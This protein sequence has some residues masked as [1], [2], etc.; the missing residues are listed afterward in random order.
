[1]VKLS[2]ICD[3]EHYEECI[4]RMYMK[5]E[6]PD[7]VKPYRFIVLIP[8]RDSQRCLGIYR[9]SL[10]AE[11]FFGAYAFPVAAPL[12]LVS[13][14]FKS[15]EL[16]VLSHE[17]R[18][19]TLSNNGK[20]SPSGAVQVVCP[21]VEGAAFFGP[22]LDLPSLETISGLSNEKVN[23]LFPDIVLCAAILGPN[24]EKPRVSEIPVTSFRAARIANLA[25]RPLEGG[26]APYSYE[27]RLGPE[28]W[29]PAFR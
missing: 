3:F 6:K 17:L 18:A 5:N 26:A 16:K 19:V 15:E 9:K 12:A 11:G 25:I 23:F 13:K 7:R 20:L 4:W 14:P 29:L 22:R 2:W 24:E 8:H 28:G 27:W 21:L 1:M 10:F